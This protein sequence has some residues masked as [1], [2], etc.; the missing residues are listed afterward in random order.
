[1]SFSRKMVIK[2]GTRVDIGL[3]RESDMSDGL[4]MSRSLK[5]PERSNRKMQYITLVIVAMLYGRLHS[6]YQT[7]CDTSGHFTECT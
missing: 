4:K 2:I 1:M 7:S 5:G 3:Q 6:I